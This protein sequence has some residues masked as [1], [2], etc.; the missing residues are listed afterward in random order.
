MSSV[1][2]EMRAVLDG[3]ADELFHYGTKFHSGRYPYGSGDQPFQHGGDFLSRV[4]KLRKEGWKETAENVKKEFGISL[5]DYRNEKAWANYT[6]RVQD[7]AKAKSLKEKGLGNSAIAR[8]MGLPNESSVRSLLNPTYKGEVYRNI[9]FDG[10]GDKA[11][12]DAYVASHIE[13]DRVIY[14]AYTSTSTVADDYSSEGK[15]V[16]HHVIQSTNGRNVEGYGNNFESEVLLPRDTGFIVEKIEYDADGTPIIYLTEVADEGSSVNRGRDQGTF[17]GDHR[18]KQDTG[19]VETNI[20]P[21]QQMRS[22][23]TA[24]D[25]V[26]SSVSGQDTA[27]NSQQ[28]KELRGVQTEVKKVRRRGFVKSEGVKLWELKKA[29]NDTQN[30]AYKILDTIARVTGINIVLY[31]SDVD[32]YGDDIHDCVVMICQSCGLDKKIPRT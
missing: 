15:F 4:E 7:M 25:E 28:Q 12:R 21:V 30:K 13:G 10:F 18:G 26:Q 27:R 16:V 2:E 32:A 5:E 11:A 3:N 19:G 8:E 22:R 23:G 31:K 14:N 29:L 9:I 1:L 20:S 17:S 24:N 6:R